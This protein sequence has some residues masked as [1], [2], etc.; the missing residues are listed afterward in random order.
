MMP[1]EKWEYLERLTKVKDSMVEKGMDA[2]L[3]VDPANICYLTGYNANSYYVPQFILVTLD[4]EMPHYL[5]RY[6][7]AKVGVVKTTWLDEN[8]T[9]YYDD[10]WLHQ[11][12]RHPV[13]WMCQEISSLGYGNKRIGVELDN[14][15]FTAYSYERFKRGLPDAKFVNATC[16]VNWIRVVKS[17]HEI[18]MVRRSGEIIYNMMSTAVEV[19]NPGVR[20]CDA[21][22]EIYHTAIKGTPEFGGDYPSGVPM[23]PVGETAGA[24]HLTWDD[25]PFPDPGT[26]FIEIVGVHYR[27]H[28]PMARSFC[29]G[30]PSERVLEHTKL[31]I[32][33]IEAALSRVKAGVTAEYV[34]A[35]WRETV[36]KYGF[37]KSDRIAYSTGL[38]Y[39]PDWGE[40]TLSFRPG[41]KDVLQP[42]MVIHMIP[43]IYLDDI[44]LS[45]SQCFRVTET[46]FERFYEFPY[47]LIVK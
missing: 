33:G 40:H 25:T 2:L 18:E 36:A 28:C 23:M 26:M 39:P 21:I 1:F 16:L 14:Y 24:P 34:E 38:A 11:T 37:T 44:G 47:D 27:Y 42:N 46:G 31:A 32:E 29:F 30:K 41:A 6:M 35:G 8:H 17:D 3:V 15:W 19:I 20:Q 22:A 4:D 10:T 5:G 45:I 12:D 13:D 9:H 43:G 7:D